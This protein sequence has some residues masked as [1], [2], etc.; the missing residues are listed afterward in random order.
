[1]RPKRSRAL[2]QGLTEYGLILAI[3]SVA[4]IVGLILVGPA[5]SSLFIDIRASV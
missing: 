3:V 4:A 5:I 2:G 1:M